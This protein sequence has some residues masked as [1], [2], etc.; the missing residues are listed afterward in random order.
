VKVVFVTST[1]TT[2]NTGGLTGADAI[3]QQRANVAGLTGTFKAWLSGGGV[4][5]K[6]RITQS[7]LPYALTNGTKVADNYADLI[8][9]TLD[10]P[11]SVTELGTSVFVYVYTGTTA[12]GDASANDCLD[13][14]ST[15]ATGGG[16]YFM[17]GYTGFADGMWT[18]I[19]SVNGCGLVQNHLYCFE[20]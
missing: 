20:Q 4:A 15:L 1:T 3:C 5:A 12:T 8:D 6:N 2:G 16:S 10:A 19:G 11:I 9:G 13:W 18:N 17:Q 7:P 14:T